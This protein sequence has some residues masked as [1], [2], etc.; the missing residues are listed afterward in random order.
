[1]K[2]QLTVED[3]NQNMR[4]DLFLALNLEGYTRSYLKKQIE[5]NNVVV[6]GIAEFKANYKVKKG[7]VIDISLEEVER[8]ED[9]KP[10]NIEIET[11][12]EDKNLLIV[13]KPVGMVVHPAT[14]N[15]KGTLVNALLY[16]YRDMKYVGERIRAGLINRIDKDTSGLVFVGKSNKA[17]WFYSRQF[18]DRQVHK[19]YL[20]IVEGDFDRVLQGRKYM[21]L[22]TYMDRNPVKRKKFAVVRD[23]VGRIA[24]S[25]FKLIARSKDGSYSL[26]RVSPETGRTHQIRVHLSY[27]G[28]PILGD[29]V[30]SGNKAERLFLHS[31]G[32]RLSLMDGRTL[33]VEAPVEGVY[34]G[35]LAENF[36]SADVKKFIKQK[37]Q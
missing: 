20:A 21:K 32:A 11:V 18:A 37:A 22:K 4:L 3:G 35:F 29:L 1:M 27:L 16:K 12:Y 31:Y 13:N 5:D 17:L 26:I 14:G 30:Y 28:F 8:N 36:K 19:D 10:E 25:K 2:K 15:Y 34:A 23:G 7:D 6:N 24:I 33:Q 9:V